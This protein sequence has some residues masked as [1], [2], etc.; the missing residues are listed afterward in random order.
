MGQRR[1]GFHLLISVSAS[2]SFY[3]F[4][5]F[6]PFAL[7][8]T[9]SLSSVSDS[10]APAVTA[11]VI[12]CTR[13]GK[14]LNVYSLTENVSVSA[15]LFIPSTCSSCH[16]LRLLEKRHTIPTRLPGSWKLGDWVT[17][18]SFITKPQS[19]AF[20]SWTLG[21][22]LLRR[23]NYVCCW[24]GKEHTNCDF[25]AHKSCLMRK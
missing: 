18:R 2:F 13:F 4:P 22:S 15:S 9:I 5:S 7:S 6:F 10:L 14:K 8:F 1:S 3:V 24:A 17:T 20:V 16:S 23:S 19:E 12:D 21:H 25:V 11:N